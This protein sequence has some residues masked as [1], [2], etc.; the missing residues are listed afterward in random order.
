MSS[1]PDLEATYVIVGGGIAGVSCAELLHQESTREDEED[2]Q[3][4]SILLVTS[5][6][7]IKAVTNIN[8]LTR[9]LASFDVREETADTFEQS[10]DNVTV[11]HATITH[12]DVESH[13]AIT[14]SGQ[15]IRYKRLCLCHGA[16]PKITLEDNPYVVGIRDTESVREFQGRL[17]NSRRV[18]ILGNGGIGEFFSNYFLRKKNHFSSFCSYRAGL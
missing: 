2:Q 14:D 8:H 4:H 1:A 10:H 9:H 17:R 5:T 13:V 7:L 3:H 11:V 18:V 15:K 16:R 12:V 6:S